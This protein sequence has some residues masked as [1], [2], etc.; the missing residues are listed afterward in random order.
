MVRV[1]ALFINVNCC[2]TWIRHVLPHDR[3]CGQNVCSWMLFRAYEN[4]F[5]PMS[6]PFRSKLDVFLD[7]CPID[8]SN[9][10]QFSINH[11]FQNELNPSTCFRWHSTVLRYNMQMKWQRACTSMHNLICECDP[12]QNIRL[13]NCRTKWIDGDGGDDDDDYDDNANAGENE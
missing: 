8:V 2:A 3:Q 1:N 11:H 4:G 9:P 12:I 7:V 13:F 5:L 6:I 10:Q